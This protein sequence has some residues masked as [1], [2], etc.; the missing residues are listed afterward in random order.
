M[1]KKIYISPSSQPA[2]TYAVGNTNEQ[3]Q[4]RKIGAA[5]EK[6]L[7]RRG[8][9]AKAGL[10]GTMYTRVKASNEMGADLHLPI[11]TNAFDKKVAG[12]RIMISKKGGEAEQIAKAIMATLA[13]ITPGASDGISTPTGIYEINSSK[14]ICVYIEVGFHDNPEE[15]QWIIDHTNEIAI[16]IADGL[17]NHYGVEHA[18]T[19]KPTT[20]KVE[21]PVAPAPQKSIDE[22]AREVLAGKHG[23]GAER[24]ESLGSLYDEVQKRVNELLNVKTTS[25]AKRVYTV[26]K[27]DTLW[28][29]AKKHLGNGGRYPEIVRLNGLNST[30]L[31]VGQK[32][33]IPEK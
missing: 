21:T 32:L 15:A 27:G 24:K 18:E 9:T 16:A 17:C 4:C 19:E 3:E 31:R 13:P 11:H 14:A 33:T 8:F 29:I 5:L 25:P 23:N 30:V 28:G 12:L 2:N 7:N 22:L 26:V 20:E 10:S 6:E 1:S